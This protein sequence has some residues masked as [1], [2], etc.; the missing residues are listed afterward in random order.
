MNI[1]AII[2]TFNPDL[3]ALR[4]LCLIL[5]ASGAQP[6]VVDNSETVALV[7]SD[8]PVGCQLLALGHNAGIAHAQNAGVADAAKLGAEL[9][10]FFDQDSVIDVS[11]VPSMVA[12]V[13]PRVAAVYGPV[14]VDAARGFEYPSYRLNRLGLPAA[15]LS[16]N[17]AAV[18]PVDLIISSGSLVTAVTF[19]LAGLMDEDFFIDYVDL[20]WCLRCRARGIP[21]YVNQN[22]TMTHSVGMRSVR[23][24]PITTFIHSPVRTYYKM[25]NPFLLLRK[26]EVRRLYALKEILSALAHHLV[27]LAMLAERRTYAGPIVA[28]LRDGLWGSTGKRRA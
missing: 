23:L 2:V 4:R 20:E 25:R 15:V 14:S 21:I 22:V 3:G 24:G 6:I 26:K 7:P 9:I 17:E 8:L 1:A 18:Y 5:A 13:D 27:Q 28:G 10:L 19:P 12:G 11:Y 16:G